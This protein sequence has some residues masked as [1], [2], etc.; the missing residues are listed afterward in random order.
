MSKSKGPEIDEQMGTF[1]SKEEVT[2][3]SMVKS[4]DYE[5]DF[6]EEPISDIVS[7][8]VKEKEDKVQEEIVAEE[9]IPEEK[10]R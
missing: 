9:I 2:G 5:N 4:D 8:H 10:I 7:E 1:R 3:R 6:E